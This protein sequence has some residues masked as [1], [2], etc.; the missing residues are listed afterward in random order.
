MMSTNTIELKN[1]YALDYISIYN[2][3]EEEVKTLNQKYEKIPNGYKITVS[4][5]S[6]ATKLIINFPHIFKDYE[7]T[8]G[9][10]DDVFLNVTGIKL[11]E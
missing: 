8:K 10:I 9:K 2:V 5:T 11:G 1:K 7:I 6:D 4:S 3:T